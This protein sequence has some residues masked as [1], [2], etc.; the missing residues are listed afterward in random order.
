MR[1]TITETLWR[2]D[3]RKESEV[4]SE[5]DCEHGGN[6]RLSYRATWYGNGQMR[7][8]INEK[9]GKRDGEC[10]WWYKNGEIMTVA[11]YKHGELVEVE[12]HN[13]AQNQRS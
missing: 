8:R 3:E 2:D 7:S 10:T 11:Y 9:D 4:T 1:K 6:I 12:D 13:E 5:Y